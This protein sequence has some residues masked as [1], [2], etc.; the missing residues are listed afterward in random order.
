MTAPVDIINANQTIISQSSD[1][2]SDTNT[3]YFVIGV[4]GPQNTGKSTIMNLLTTMNGSSNTEY[5]IINSKN[6]LFRVRC[7]KN[8]TTPSAITETIQMYVTTDRIILL[9]SPPLFC[10]KFKKNCTQ[11]ELDDLKTISL[12]L[13]ICHLVLVVVDNYFNTNLIRYE[14]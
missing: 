1:Y 11:T 8:C 7:L 4:I 5:S 3:D 13:S 9:D 6:P 12:L 2:L 14:N 10:N